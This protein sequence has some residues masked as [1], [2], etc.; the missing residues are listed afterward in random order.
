MAEIIGGGEPVNDSERAVIR[1]LRDHGPADWFFWHNIDVPLHG[2]RKGDIDILLVTTHAVMLIDVK[3][4]HGRIEVAGRRWYPSNRQSFFSPVDKLRNH[5]RAFKGHLTSRGLNSRIFV[6]EVVVLTAPDARLVDGSTSPDADALHVIT[7][8]AD[9]IPELS[10]PE[11][12]RTGFLRDIRQ[13]RNQLIRAIDGTVLPRTGPPRFGHWEVTESLGE[14]EEVTEYRARNANARTDSSVLLRVY[15]ADPFQPED[16]RAAERI[17]LSNAYD[18]LVRLPSDS[19][20]VGCRDFFP[21][22]D[23]SQYVLVLED[24]RASALL[25][26]LADPQLALTA[27]EKLR[28]IRDMLHGLAHA[29]AH[30][31]LHRALSPTTVLVTGTSGGMLTGFDYARPED[32][33]SPSQSVFNRLAGA[34]DP[35]YVAPECQNQPQRM[36]KASDV[37]AA[38]VIAFQVLTGELPFATTTDQQQRSSVLPS[39]PMAAAGLAQSLIDLLRRMCAREPDARPSAAEA[40]EAFTA[41]AMTR[42]PVRPERQ[43]DYRNLPEGYQLTTKFTVQRRIGGGS[44]G[45]VYQVYDNLAGADRAVKIVDRDRVSPVGRLQQEYH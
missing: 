37:Y 38:G 41:A 8:L 14:T 1:H 18:M 27:D 12:V 10:K 31:V 7:G 36:S 23:E 20:V 44:F 29:H 22:E 5:A 33:R 30:R 11:R 26:H 45:V 6:N 4:T 28:V 24:V 19:C 16:V 3:G 2:G 17:A 21:N 35:A 9:L 40:Q 42:P 15:H 25:L 13:Y 32:P 43:A 34:L 39:G